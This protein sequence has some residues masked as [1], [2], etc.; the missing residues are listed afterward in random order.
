LLLQNNV[1]SLRAP[2]SS[3]RAPAAQFN[4]FLRRS[5]SHSP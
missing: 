4:A 3:Q 1:N 2:R 5:T